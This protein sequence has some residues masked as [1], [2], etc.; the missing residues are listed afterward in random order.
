MLSANIIRYLAPPPGRRPDTP[1]VNLAD[2]SPQVGQEVVLTTDLKDSNFDPV[3]N[4]D[5]VVT[6]TRP[7]GK[8]YRM[9][10]RDVPEEP[11]YYTSRVLIEQPGAYQILAKHGKFES[12]REFLA[13]ASA[14]EFVDLSVD[15]EGM[16]R[17]VKAADGELVEGG[18]AP[19]LQTVDMRPARQSVER[20]LEVWNSPLVL[21]AFIVLVSLDCWVRKRQGMV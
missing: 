13:G 4:A 10:P 12:K 8:S 21:V 6:V 15:R 17:L 7:D 9:Y 5:M 3:R 18:V 19:W 1:Q 16:K 2:G 20:D 11:G 14:G